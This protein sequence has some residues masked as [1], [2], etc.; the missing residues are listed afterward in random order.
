MKETIIGKDPQTAAALLEAGDLVAIPTETVYGLAA[1]AGN[2]TAIRK[3]FA[4]KG[5]PA[6]HPLIVHTE[7]I[8][9]ISRY[10]TGIPNTAKRL[11]EHFAPG[12]LTVLLQPNG[13]LS[14]LVSGGR[15]QVAFRVP[16]HPLA[17]GVLR[18]AGFP[19]VA[20]SANPFTRT[21]PTHPMHVLRYFN[22]VIPYIL[23]GGPC[24]VGIESTVV[25]FED[26]TV[27]IYRAGAITAEE[28]ALVAGGAVRVKESS[29]SGPAPGMHHLHYTPRTPLV[30]AEDFTGME[31]AHPDKTGLLC[32]SGYR[33]GWPRE[34]QFVLSMKG[35]LE[36]AARNLYQ[37][38]HE[39]DERGLSLIVAETAPPHGLGI[40]INDRLRRAAGHSF[41]LQQQILNP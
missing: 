38:L 21:S 32:F 35:N 8:G 40:A 17:L 30:L 11:L 1:D 36:T 2:E 5:R 41:Q 20:P 37:G 24:T 22:R 39:L 6:H 9:V 19:L 14:R 7:S 23:D 3:V 12:P 28:V 34:N 15:P 27:V 13:R 33:A 4:A 16:A 26:D 25:G 18:S 10:V 29:G 31:G